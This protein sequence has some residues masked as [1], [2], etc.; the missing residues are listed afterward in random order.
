MR[1]GKRATK[2]GVEDRH[3]AGEDHELDPPLDEPVADGGVARGA[4]PELGAQKTRDGTP[5]C[6]GA[7]EARAED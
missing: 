3:V 4:R 2:A 6:P 5:A 1:S 7:V